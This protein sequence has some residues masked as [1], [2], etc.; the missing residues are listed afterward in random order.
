MQSAYLNN[1]VSFFFFVFG[2]IEMLS[3]LA[4]LLF[5]QHGWTTQCDRDSGPSGATGCLQ[6]SRYNNQYQWTTYVTNAYIQR[7]KDRLKTCYWNQCMLEVHNKGSGL[8]TKECSCNPSSFTT[9]TNYS[10]PAKCYS[11][12][13]DLCD[14]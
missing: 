14:W 10:L 8:V 6:I 2:R 4:L 9:H 5:A 13:G 3:L 11:P 1:L 12:S 7:K